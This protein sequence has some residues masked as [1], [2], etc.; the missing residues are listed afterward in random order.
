MFRLLA[1]DG[2]IPSAGSYEI[3]RFTAARE[4]DASV[5]LR[6][7]DMAAIAAY[8][9]HGRIRGGEHEAACDRATAAWTADYLRGKD[10]LE[11][12]DRKAGQGP[13]AGPWVIMIG[14]AR[15]RPSAG[16]GRL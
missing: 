10:T 1:R 16:S 11:L 4:R 9:R 15:T 13:T 6:D 14:W 2:Q 8:D 7:G 5:R 12:A 3:R